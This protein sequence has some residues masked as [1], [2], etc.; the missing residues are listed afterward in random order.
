VT[1]VNGQRLSEH[2][3]Y[4]KT[5]EGGGERRSET[6]VRRGGASLRNVGTGGI[7][8]VFP[9]GKALTEERGGGGGG[10]LFCW[11]CSSHTHK[12]PKAC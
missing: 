11:N 8:I 9:S 7:V 5:A 3:V 2:F 6:P 12:K 10:I 4:R 1:L